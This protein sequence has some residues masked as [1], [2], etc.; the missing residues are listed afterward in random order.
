MI[1]R[2]WRVV[3]DFWLR[4]NIESSTAK[5]GATIVNMFLIPINPSYSFFRIHCLNSTLISL[6]IIINFQGELLILHINTE[7]RKR[8]KLEIPRVT[9]SQKRIT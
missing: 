3:L 7:I 5:V 4:L 6:K 9:R 8:Q 1:E 2:L